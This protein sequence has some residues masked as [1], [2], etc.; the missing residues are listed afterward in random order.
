MNVNLVKIGYIHL[1]DAPIV[2]AAIANKIAGFV[3]LL[4]SLTDMKGPVCLGDNT[5]INVARVE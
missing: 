1:M 5:P 2:E 4:G 3:R